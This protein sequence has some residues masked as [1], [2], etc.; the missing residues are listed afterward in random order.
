[1][2]VSFSIL[3]AFSTMWYSLNVNSAVSLPNKNRTGRQSLLDDVSPLYFV[4]IMHSDKEDWDHIHC[5]NRII[6]SCAVASGSICLYPLN[7]DDQSH[8][9]LQI[10]RTWLRYFTSGSFANIA[11]RRLRCIVHQRLQVHLPRHFIFAKYWHERNLALFDTVS[12]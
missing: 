1:M 9:H 7:P 3:I 6:T 8:P 12:R 11:R 10:S 2:S 5:E 4:L